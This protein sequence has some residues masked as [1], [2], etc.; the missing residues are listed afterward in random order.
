MVRKA[1]ILPET[2][3]RWTMYEFAVVALLA[4][5]T[6]KLVDYITDVIE[7]VRKFR[8][9]LTFVVAVGATL[10]LDYSVFTGWGVDIRNADVGVWVTGFM[11]AGLTV[12]W[13]ALFGYLTHDRAASD[14]TL[15]EG[16]H[17]RAA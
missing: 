13:R 12:P 8:S 3:G 14:E 17:I 7:P 4:L 9:L 16:T 15:G 6:L 11:V 1:Q 10:L 2:T 5:A